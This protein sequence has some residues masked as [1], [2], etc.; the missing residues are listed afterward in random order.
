MTLINWTCIGLLVLVFLV[1]FQRMIISIRLQVVKPPRNTDSS[2][3]QKLAYVRQVEQ[4]KHVSAM[5][6]VLFFLAVG[7]LLN[8]YSNFKVQAQLNA[9][10]EQ[11]TI[12]KDDIVIMKMEQ[13][14]LINKLPVKTYPKAGVGLQDYSWE[15]LFTDE[16]REKQYALESDLSRKLSP[17]F[18][19]P[20]TLIILD[21]PTQTLT[22]ALTSDLTSENNRKQI[23]E[24]VKAFAK[25]AEGIAK[26]T[27]IS[28]QL[29][30]RDENKLK[31]DYSCTFARENGKAPF[32]IVQAD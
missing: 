23:I 22:I 15:E 30:I 14:K 7:L 27:Q 26:L 5:L 17:Y 10:N 28:F 2:F 11:N 9:L 3:Q 25:E 6:C 1:W 8:T 13:K 29:T 19:L 16:S 4:T 24:N 18:G 31:Q 12:L 20:T 21:I 32:S